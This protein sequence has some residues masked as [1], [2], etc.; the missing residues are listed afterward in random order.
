MNSRSY[1]VIFVLL[2][3]SLLVILL[4]QGFWIRNF[5]S[6]KADEF[7]RT[8]YQLL[9]DVSTKL[10][11]RENIHFIKQ[12][13]GLKT[14]LTKKSS[15]KNNDVKVVVS[16]STSSDNINAIAGIDVLH[17]MAMEAGPGQNNRIIISDS[18]VSVNGG[19]QTIVINK[20]VSKAIPKKQDL[21][22]L[23]DKMMM[24]I[25]TIDVSP[26]EEIKPDSLKSMIKKELASKGIL[27]PFEFQLRKQ[28]KNT[29]KI[30]VQSEGFKDTGKIYKADLSNKRIFSD[31]NYLYLQF[32]GED[33]YLLSSMK[34]ILLLSALFSLLIIIVFY[35]TL[36]TILKQKRISEI[37]NDF[38]NNM[39][40]ELKTPIATISLAIDA[41]NNPQVKSDQARFH[42]YTA[43]LKEENRKLNNH[44]ERVLQMALIDKGNLQLH[45]THVDLSAIIHASINTHKLQAEHFNGQILFEGAQTPV[46]IIGDE[47]HL[48][49]AFNNLLDNA[50]K[51]SKENCLVQIALHK[52]G[53]G[54]IITIKDNGIGIEPDHQKKIFEKF[55]RVQGGNLHDVKGF[56]LGL[57][58]VR[59][60]IESHNG[61]IELQSEKGKGSTFTIKLPANEA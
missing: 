42:Q 60:I 52:T 31:H 49:A 20:R 11:E 4:L 3:F 58:Y 9:S 55:Y 5:Y 43:I 36:K 21:D 34:N 44:V 46:F 48:L 18:M 22:K 50:L 26:I 40:H 57:S 14:K 13:S 45:K 2:S 10:N 47:F 56:G 7:N 61:S 35:L 19:H 32:P 53:T 59:S 41:I 54:L 29:D 37:K 38:I 39:T 12:S 23:M 16:S 27:I 6:Q 1:K 15:K 33:D 17:E 8:I 28:D 24:E 30:F 25:Q 51:Y